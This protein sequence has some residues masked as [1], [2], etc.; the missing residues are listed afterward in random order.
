MDAQIIEPHTEAMVPESTKETQDQQLD[1][2]AELHAHE[3]TYEEPPPTPTQPHPEGI[4]V[5][6][7]EE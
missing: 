4:L 1:I 6:L 5:I 2:S 3:L 7:E